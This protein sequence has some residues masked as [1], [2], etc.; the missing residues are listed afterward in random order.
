MTLDGTK[1]FISGGEFLRPVCRHGPHR[2]EGPSGISSLLV[3]NG[4]PGLSFGAR[5]KEDGLEVAADRY[6]DPVK[7]APF[8]LN[9]RIGAEGQGFHIAMRAL[10]GGRLNIAAPSLGGAQ[11]CLDRTIAYTRE[12]Q[13]SAPAH[14]LPGPRSSASPT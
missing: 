5:E 3:E 6:R 4:T 10:D 2:G 14:R 7:T 12:R 13:P 11:F 8:R 9:N 1:A